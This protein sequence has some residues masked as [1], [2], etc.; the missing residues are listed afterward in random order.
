MF[1]LTTTNIIV[2][3][4][5]AS[6]AVSYFKLFGCFIDAMSNRFFTQLVYQVGMVTVDAYLFKGKSISKS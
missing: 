5:T 4:L 6:T 3:A 1:C 2:T